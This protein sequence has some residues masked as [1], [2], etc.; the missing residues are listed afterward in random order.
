MPSTKVTKNPTKSN[1]SNKDIEVAPGK[2]L[3]GVG[4]SQFDGTAQ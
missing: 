4:T 1:L 2:S 3:E